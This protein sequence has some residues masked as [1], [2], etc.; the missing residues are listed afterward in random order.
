MLINP[1]A[2]CFIVLKQNAA[3]ANKPLPG[4]PYFDEFLSHS[5]DSCNW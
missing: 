4:L 3:V 1:N 5:I 2:N